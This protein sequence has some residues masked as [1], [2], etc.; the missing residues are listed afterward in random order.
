MPSDKDGVDFT[1][2]K[3]HDVVF[4]LSERFSN[5]ISDSADGLP[6]IDLHVSCHGLR[7][8]DNQP[9][10]VRFIWMFSCYSSFGYLWVLFYSCVDF[11][12]YF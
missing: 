12:F 8:P 11:Y 2:G 3:T 4:E 6:S 5:E 1:R 9:P 7:T 10:K